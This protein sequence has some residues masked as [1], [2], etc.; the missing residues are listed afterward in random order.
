M[1]LWY[2][3]QDIPFMPTI[4]RAFMR[5]NAILPNQNGPNDISIESRQELSA[6]PHAAASKQTSVTGNLKIRAVLWASYVMPTAIWRFRGSDTIQRDADSIG[7]RD[8]V[9]TITQLYQFRVQFSE[10]ISR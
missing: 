2:L 3:V 9:L 10:R 7:A 8:D 5:A 4:M 6:K 1:F